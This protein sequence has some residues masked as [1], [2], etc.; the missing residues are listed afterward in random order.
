ML[1]LKKSFSV[2]LMSSDHWVA[3]MT[4]NQ[5]SPLPATHTSPLCLRSVFLP[6]TP[7]SWSPSHPPSY[8]LSYA[9]LS[10]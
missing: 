3:W 9:E 4:L 2:H 7:L 10:D 1:L 6:T 8:P 5:S